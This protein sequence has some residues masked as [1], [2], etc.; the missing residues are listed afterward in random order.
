[1]ELHVLKKINNILFIH[2][3]DIRW[4]QWD[5]WDRDHKLTRCTETYGNPT[6]YKVSIAMNTSVHA[7][8]I[9]YTSP[10]SEVLVYAHFALSRFQTHIRHSLTDSQHVHR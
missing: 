10:A 2:Y 7:Q 4:V 1:V 6:V 8:G 9:I 5:D 3:R